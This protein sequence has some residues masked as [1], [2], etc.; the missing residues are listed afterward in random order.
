MLFMNLFNLFDYLFTS[1]FMNLPHPWILNTL[2]SFFSAKGIYIVIWLGI[3]L[4][5]VIFEEKRNKTFIIY[6]F[7]SFIIA[8]LSVAMIKNI[9]S[10]PRPFAANFQPIPINYPTD[11]SFPSGHATISFASATLLS[12]FDKKRKKYFYLIAVLIA[13]SR[14][15]LGYHYVSDVIVGSLLGWLISSI[16][17]LKLKRK[18]EEIKTTT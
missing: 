12:V 10:R 11:Y 15:Y 4:Y 5:I 18:N 14:V 1:F 17:L 13:F 16:V 3:F 2:F 8:F 9:T 6:F 7:A